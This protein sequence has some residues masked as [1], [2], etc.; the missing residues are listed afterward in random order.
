M[1]IYLHPRNTRRFNDFHFSQFYAILEMLCFS[2]HHPVSLLMLK[3]CSYIKYPRVCVT[4]LDGL[5]QAAVSKVV[6]AIPCCCFIEDCITYRHKPVDKCSVFLVAQCNASSVSQRPD[7]IDKIE[8]FHLLGCVFESGLNY[9]GQNMF[10]P[11]ETRECF[12]TRPLLPKV[13]FLHLQIW[14]EAAKVLKQEKEESKEELSAAER[15]AS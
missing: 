5:N 11:L 12:C 10:L 8:N 15:Q 14:P 2:R 9:G 6:L 3:T 13:R 1:N 7:K 4:Q